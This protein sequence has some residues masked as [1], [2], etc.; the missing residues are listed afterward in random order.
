M[1]LFN[2]P[3]NNSAISP[4]VLFLITLFAVT[5]TSAEMVFKYRSDSTGGISTSSSEKASP[6][7]Y[8]PA[9]LNKIG[10]SPGCDRMLIIDTRTLRSAASTN[11]SIY[12]GSARFK[13]SA[14]D[15]SFDIKPSDP[16]APDSV[17]DTTYTFGDS[18]RNIF[19]G[20]IEDFSFLFYN[21]D[22]FN[23]DIGYWDVSSATNM[24]RMFTGAKY[25]DQDIGSWDVSNVTN[26]AEMFVGADNFNQNIGAWDVSNVTDMYRMFALTESFN[27]D[28]GDWDVSSVTSLSGMFHS[29]EAFNQDITG[30]DISSVTTYINFRYGSS[31][32]RSNTPPMLR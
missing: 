26:M 14:G 10:A 8:D 29:T 9:N 11:V 30:W 13:S 27:Q 23:G 21:Y 28:V 5:D 15:G 2:N 20:Q 25:F 7:C 17:T 32:R 16:Y 31:L 22:S 24:R 3:L 19:T 6:D 18:D 12:G 1:N 4:L